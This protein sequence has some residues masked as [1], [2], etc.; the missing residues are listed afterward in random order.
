MRATGEE[1]DVIDK[2]VDRVGADSRSELVAVALEA[3]YVR[4]RTHSAR[5]PSRRARP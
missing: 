2:L 5:G 4:N 3:C 1:L